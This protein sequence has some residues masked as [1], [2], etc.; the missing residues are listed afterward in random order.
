MFLFPSFSARRQVL[1]LV[2]RGQ[3]AERRQALHF[4]ATAAVL[5]EP[6]ACAIAAAANAAQQVGAWPWSKKCLYLG[7]IAML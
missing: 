7:V 4:A 5:R 3:A 2:L 1:R 6:P